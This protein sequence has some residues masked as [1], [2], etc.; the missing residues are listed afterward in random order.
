MMAKEAFLCPSKTVFKTFNLIKS[1]W[2]WLKL[3]Y[4]WPGVD[5]HRTAGAIHF[6][7]KGKF[8]EERWIFPCSI[9]FQLLPYSNCPWLN[10]KLTSSKVFVYQIWGRD[11]LTE[12]IIDFLF[13][14]YQ[15]VT[16]FLEF[17][18]VV[19]QKWTTFRY[20]LLFSYSKKN[21]RFFKYLSLQRILEMKG[22]QLHKEVA[23]FLGG[24]T[25]FRK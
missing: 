9:G 23:F 20:L 16:C 7:G 22:S 4:A 10:F 8:S 1:K 21:L 11:Y 2:L 18:G 19:N 24:S 25:P 5:I 12:I 13:F 15:N 14:I 6:S 17:L 3:P